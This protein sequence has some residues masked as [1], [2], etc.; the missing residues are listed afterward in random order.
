LARKALGR[1]LSALIPGETSQQ[2]MLV[3]EISQIDP[4][5]F[6]PREGEADESLNEL[7]ASI[8]EKGIVQPLVVRRKKERFEL[9]CGG[10]RLKA[11]KRAGLSEVPAVV[12]EASDSEVLELAIIENVQRENLNPME[13]ATSY[14]KLM[15]TF[16]Y[17]QAE[18]AAKVGKDRSTV[19]NLL[20][21]LELPEKIRSYIKSGKISPGH[22]RALLAVKSNTARLAIAEKIVKSSL[23]VRDVERLATKR[24]S[25]QPREMAPE[26]V[27]LESELSELL[28]TRVRIKTRRKK[29]SIEIEFYSSDDLERILDALRGAASL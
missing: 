11:A 25:S 12:K 9:I 1:G 18:V 16:N 23:T 13:E 14:R 7:I 17:T 19:A 2:E 28:G 27:S 8:K 15:K 3:L 5:P 22:G 21:L 4:N 10:R 24:R 29:G 20:R 26:M 6:E